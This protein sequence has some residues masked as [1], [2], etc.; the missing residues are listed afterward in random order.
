MY[1]EF[2]LCI[3]DFSNDNEPGDYWYDCAV[4]E[5]AEILSKF[6]EPDWV[7]LFNELA[8]KSIFWKTRLVECLG[9]LKN[10]HELDIILALI[11]TDNYDLFISCVDSLRSM[12]ICDLSED[13]LGKI[14]DKIY[15]LEQSASLPVKS[16]LESFSRK[17]KCK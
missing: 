13:D 1:K 15:H 16:I 4:V 9:D 11:D 6:K 14:N 7:C 8:H 3:T 5:S 12:D 17:F 10:S 2:D